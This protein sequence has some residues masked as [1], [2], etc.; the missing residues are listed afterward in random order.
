MIIRT[1]AFLLFLLPFCSH[2]QQNEFRDIAYIN[3]LPEEDN[4]R[5]LNLVIPPNSDTPPP[6]LI[7]IGGGA[8]SYVDRNVEMDMAKRI[9]ENGIAVAS[10]GHRLSPATWRDP[11]LNTGVQHPAHM[12]DLAAAVKWL[13][14]HAGT[15][16]FDKNNIFIG[17]FSSGAH[18]A[19]LITMDP[20]YL[21]SAGLPSDLF[22]GVI[23]VSGAY[24]MVDY[25]NFLKN[26]DRPELA[27]LHVQAVFGPT[28]QDLISA[29]P[30]TYMENLSIP[31]LLMSDITVANY[32]RLFEERIQQTDLTNV[33]VEYANE[34]THAAL[35]KN[36]SYEA[37]SSYRNL[38]VEFILQNSRKQ[39]ASKAN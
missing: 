16:G 36:M 24:D 27:E 5:R 2:S 35:W 11:S 31:M 33:R 9:A 6:L 19:A 32:T 26:S 10:V 13:Y 25:Y 22:S 29:S 12:Q 15:Y 7:W 39:P 20:T 17:G 3:G 18:L 1:L 37:E 23:P 21:E 4:L 34:F 14:D 30:M 38:I 8:W 28:Q